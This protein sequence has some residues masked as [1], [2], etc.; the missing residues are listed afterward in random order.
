MFPHYPKVEFWIFNYLYLDGISFENI[1]FD[2][3]FNEKK[4]GLRRKRRSSM[5]KKLFKKKKE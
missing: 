5:Y 1:D 4:I 2:F 3:F